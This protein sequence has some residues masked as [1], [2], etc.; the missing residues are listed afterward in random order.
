MNYQLGYLSSTAIVTIEEKNMWQKSNDV[1]S[2]NIKEI[3]E[4]ID[5]GINTSQHVTMAM[6]TAKLGN[7]VSAMYVCSFLTVQWRQ[8]DWTVK[9]TIY[10][11]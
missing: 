3:R 5:D 2:N 6:L 10:I 8:W 7:S 1:F 4:E 11:I 9:Y